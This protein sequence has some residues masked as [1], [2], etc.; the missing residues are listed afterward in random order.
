[1]KTV[2]PCVLKPVGAH[3]WRKGKNW[4]LVGARKAISVDSA[5]DLRAQYANVSRANAT[6][7]GAGNDSRRRRVFDHRRLL[8]GSARSIRGGGFN[9]Q[10]L[11]QSRE[12]FG[13]GCI[14]QTVDRPELFEPTIRLLES[15]QY[16][17]I[18]EVEYKWDGTTQTFQLIEINPRPWDQHR[19]GKYAGCDVIYLAYLDHAELRN[20]ADNAS[21][22]PILTPSKW[23][24]ED[25][26][27]LLLCRMFW[28]RDP[29]LGEVRRLLAGRR[30]YA[31][32]SL[33]DPLPFLLL[34]IGE[35][36]PTV[37][38]AAMRRLWSALKGFVSADS[39]VGNE[40]SI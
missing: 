8:Y 11:L 40:G 29:K 30:I 20:P 12:G 1:M 21:S 7:P 22:A 19:L 5:N 3:H 33:R 35:A 31:V 38:A 4:K 23:V 6:C 36:I 32:W 25:G 28:Q 39:T 17:G 26:V 16:T 27:F 18:A 15:I 10:K 13:T 24:A 2:Y 34:F 37:L 14:V 9:F